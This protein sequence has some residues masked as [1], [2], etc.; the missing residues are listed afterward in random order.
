MVM[1]EQLLPLGTSSFSALR[2]EGQI[3]VDKTELIFNLAKVRGKFFLARPRRFGKSLLVSTFESLFK[4]GLVDFSGLAIEALWEDKKTYR[5]VRLDFSGAKNFIDTADFNSKFKDLLIDSFFPAG[6]RYEKEG[7]SVVSQL[8]R[9]LRTLPNSSLV[10]LIDEYDAPLTACLNDPTTFNFIRKV[11]SDFYSLLKA[12]DTPIRFLFITGITKF[13][14]AGIFSEF[15]NLVDISFAPEYGQLLGYSREEL[16]KYF[17]EFIE[18]SAIC[19]GL[20]KQELLHRLTINYDGYCFETTVQQKVFAP[21]SVLNF[22]RAPSLGFVNYWF[23][24]GGRS[25]VLVQ[26]FSSHELANPAEYVKEK[27]VPLDVLNGSLD[28]NALSDVALLTQAGYL[29]LK[30]IENRTAFVGYPNEEV[31]TSMARLYT[32]LLLTGKTPEQIGAGSI[33]S[34]MESGNTEEVVHMLNRLFSSIDYLRY[35]VKDESS[36]RAFVQVFISGAGLKCEIENHSAHGRSDLEVK[37]GDIRWIL[38]FKISSYGQNPETKLFEAVEQLEKY[39]RDSSGRL[40]KTA[41]VFSIEKR[42]FV[43][44]MS[45]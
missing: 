29:T 18:Q 3:Y 32:E 1:N 35:P 33:T 26:Y 5:V 6:F 40:R 7:T 28:L 37:A 21:W 45:V 30:R 19:L 39:G 10:I 8:S 25:T 34:K 31:R 41:L 15:N 2:E 9:W 27:S 17:S 12:N 4:H 42:E 36:L 13:S 43:K 38:E 11:L 20:E 23:E 14:Q 22:F 24:S 16:K 44:W